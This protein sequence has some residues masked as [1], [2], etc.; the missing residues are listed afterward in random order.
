MKTDY[1]TLNIDNGSVLHKKNRNPLTLVSISQTDTGHLMRFTQ[2]S[3][4][5]CYTGSTQEQNPII[6]QRSER[7]EFWLSKESHFGV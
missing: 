5:Y 4:L 3:I 1:H 7:I 2:C 6:W